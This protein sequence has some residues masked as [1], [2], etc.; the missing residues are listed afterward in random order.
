MYQA[1]SPEERQD[2]LGAL[3]KSLLCTICFF[4]LSVILIIAGSLSPS[5]MSSVS[6]EQAQKGTQLTKKNEDNWTNLASDEVGIYWNQYFYNCTNMMDVI[7]TNAKPQF[8]EFGPYVYRE[9]SDYTDLVYKD[10]FIEFNGE[11]LHGV[12]AT[13]KQS[14]TFDSDPTGT[15]D[16]PLYLTNQA[17]FGA[18]YSQNEPD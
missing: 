16:T 1:L 12:N 8:Q 5:T 18:W 14:V 17:L 2:K 9:A 11:S 15:V 4:C 7:Y 6:L 13:Y 10:N 3:R